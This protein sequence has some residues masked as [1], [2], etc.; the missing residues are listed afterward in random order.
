MIITGRYT[1]AAQGTIRLKAKRAGEPYVREIPVSFPALQSNNPVVASLWAREKIDDLMSQDWSGAQQGNMRKDLRETV[2]NIGLEY[3]LMTQFTSFVAVEGRVVTEGGKPKRIQVPVELPE[4]VQYEQGWSGG[5]GGGG[6]TNALNAPTKMAKSVMV[7][8]GAP[9]PPPPSASSSGVAGGVPGGQMGGVL[10]GI[11]LAAPAAAVPASNGNG[12]GGGIGSGQGASVGPG[13]GGGYGGGV[14]RVG[15]GVSAPRAIHSPDPVYS[16]EA[17][18]ANLQGTVVLFAV[19]GIDGRATDVHVARS[20]GMGLD[21]KAVEAL[22]RW[23]FEPAKKDG[24]PV[25]VQVNVEFTFMNGK[26]TNAVT[27]MAG[28]SSAPVTLKPPRTIDTKL[29]PQLVAAYDCWQSQTDMSKGAAACKLAD[30]KVLVRVIVDGD[31]V[32]VLHELQAAGFEPQ[33]GTL[34]K[35]LVGRISI[36]KL[37]ALAE[38]EAVKVR[39]SRISGRK[40][41]C[42]QTKVEAASF[43]CGTVASPGCA[44]FCGT[45][46]PTPDLLIPVN[47]R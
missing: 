20:L 42:S 13:R 34:P 7:M 11:M 2:T 5:G 15:G 1:A 35:Q 3:R 26:S 45:R 28:R 39:D 41:D 25:A 29:S 12:S 46:P 6:N 14:F 21:E 44:T 32:A 31:P 36:E 4:D 47:S 18:K 27:P 43:W 8:N 37:A 23:T 40:V 16:D 22:R 17:L 24:N 10:G 33:P 38:I 9:P 30:D 19:V